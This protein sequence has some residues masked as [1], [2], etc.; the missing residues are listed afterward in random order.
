MGA[1]A[2]AILA[3]T[4]VQ[5]MEHKHVYPILKTQEII[6]YYRYIYAIMYGQNKTNVEQ[7]FDKFN[8]IQPC[9]AFTIKKEQHIEINYLD[10]T[11]HCKEKN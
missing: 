8:Y 9:I 10:I 5:H 6:T 3:K 7:T 4:F 2:S 11:I 1:P